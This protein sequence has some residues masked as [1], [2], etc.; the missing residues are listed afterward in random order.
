MKVKWLLLGATMTWAA[1]GEM[2]TGPADS[3]TTTSDSGS[4]VVDSGTAVVDAG[5]EGVDAGRLDSGTTAVDAGT[6]VVDAGLIYNNCTEAKFVDKKAENT[7]TVNFG[8]ALG[9]TYSPACVLIAVGH[10][11]TFKGNFGFHPIAPGTPGSLTAGSP[12]NPI[13]ARSSGSSD[14]TANF[15]VA[16]DYP[17]ICTDHNGSGMSGVVRVR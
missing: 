3:G 9:E 17:Y 2:T 5:S 16:G 13:V 12:N 6:T 7:T 11:V 8:A 15:A 1:C 10:S 4:A 14:L